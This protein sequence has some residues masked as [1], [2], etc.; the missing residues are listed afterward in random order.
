MRR[1]KRLLFSNILILSSLIVLFSYSG[2]RGENTQDQ[3]FQTFR[4]RNIGPANMMG[5]ISA[6]DALDKDYRIVLVGSASGGV[7]KSTNSGVTWQPIFDEYGSGSIGDVA[8]FQANPDIIWV[9]TG[10]AHNR[11]SSGWGDGIYKS[12]DGGKTFRNMDLKETHQIARIATHPTDPDI[13]YVAAVG[14]L[15]GYSGSRG[16]FKTI[17]GGETWEKL[18]NGL[19]DNEKAGCTEIKMHPTDPDILFCAMYHRLRKPWHFHSGS[20]DG[21]LFKTID[22][23][24]SW[25]KLTSGLPSGDIG[26]VGIDI[27]AAKPEVV[28]ASVEASDQLPTDMSIPGPGVYRSDDGGETWRYLLR[29]TSRPMYHGRIAVNPLDDNLIY[30][31]TMTCGFRQGTKMSFTSLPTRELI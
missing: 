28:V 27:C 13:V 4:W 10:E 24:K 17:D 25:R 9:G 30:V 5:R 2:L 21:G 16:L 1:T 31:M 26:R 18:T 11:N 3:I 14:H 8:F 19:P 22:G 15:W 12:T 7:F 29:H 20:P 6:L 23:G